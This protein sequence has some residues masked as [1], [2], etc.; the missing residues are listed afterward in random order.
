LAE[1]D[2]QRLD[3]GTRKALY[4]ELGFGYSAD[5]KELEAAAAWRSSLGARYDA[6]IALK[7]TPC[8]TPPRA[9]R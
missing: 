1:R 9:H 4:D 3:P 8:R 2:A 6:P 7:L 5:G